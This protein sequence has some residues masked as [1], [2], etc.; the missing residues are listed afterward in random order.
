[1]LMGQNSMAF[2]TEK[3]VISRWLVTLIVIGQ[4]VSMTE[5]A[6]EDMFFI[7]VLETFHGPPRSNQ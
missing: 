1:M 2:C 6:H 4:E 5:R 3:K 7:W